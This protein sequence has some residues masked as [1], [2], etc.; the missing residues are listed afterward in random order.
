MLNVVRLLAG[1]YEENAYLAWPEHGSEALLVDPGGNADMLMNEIEKRGLTLT[2]ILLTHGHFDHILAVPELRKRTDAK[3]WI[4]E[5]DES[6]LFDPYPLKLPFDYR[7][8]FKGIRL[9][10]DDK[11]SGRE[12]NLFGM[13]IEMIETP[14]HTPGGVCY[15]LPDEGIMFTGDTLF[16]DGYGR[17]DFATGRAAD[18]RASLAML[19][20]MPND[21]MIFPGHEESAKMGEAKRRIRI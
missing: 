6:M 13:R 5:M 12:L 2:H 1:P 8:Q 20:E 9:N 16:A 15:Y 10:D 17:T 7:H 4:H 19:F 3:I 11:V 14:G 21:I 18:M